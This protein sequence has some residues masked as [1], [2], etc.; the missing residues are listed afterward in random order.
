MAEGLQLAEKE[1]KPIMLFVHRSWCKACKN[2]VPIIKQNSAVRELNAKFV[3]I[4]MTGDDV[5]TE[6]NYAPDGAYVP[7]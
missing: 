4:E 1:Q 2:L 7:R 6:E 3:T 5:A